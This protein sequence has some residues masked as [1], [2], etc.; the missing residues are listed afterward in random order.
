[1]EVDK[2]DEVK[3]HNARRTSCAILNK[4]ARVR[5]HVLHS[6]SSDDEDKEKKYQDLCP[7]WMGQVFQVQYILRVYL[8]HDGFFTG[9]TS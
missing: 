4:D 7:S 9:G 8:K 6:E 1:M 5:G 2:S 3:N